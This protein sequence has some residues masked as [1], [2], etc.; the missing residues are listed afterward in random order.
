M[1]QIA[2]PYYQ[3]RAV[4]PIEKLAAVPAPGQ[5]K[6]NPEGQSMLRT[7]Y[8]PWFFKKRLEEFEAIGVERDLAG[9]PVA[10][11]PSR[12]HER[13]AGQLGQVQDVPG[14]QEDGA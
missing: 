6:G 4:M 5:Y 3:T 10:K 12:L 2:P 13:P 1:V 7:A 9:L 11:V 8:R 14:V